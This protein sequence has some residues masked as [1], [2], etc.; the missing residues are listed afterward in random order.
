[1]R[2][3]VALVTGASTGLG[4]AI[5]RALLARTDHHVVLTARAGSMD[6]FVDAGLAE[7]ER[8][9]LRPLD[10]TVEAQRRALIDEIERELGGVDALINNAGVSYRAVVEHVR[11][12]ERLTQMDVNFRSPMELARLVLPRMR[13]RRRGHVVNVSSVAGMM[14]MPT[15]A[16]YAASKFA[17]EGASE[18]LWYEVRPF[19]IRVTLVQ[20]GFLHSS[21]FQNVR[22][23]VLSGSSQETPED[24]YH[25][26]YA[27]MSG[28]IER[29]MRRAIATPE[30]VARVVVRTI[31]RRRPPLRVTAT[32]DAFF[33]HW[34]RRLLPRSFYHWILYRMLPGVSA[35]GRSSRAVSP[36]LR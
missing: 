20:P 3:P 14:A 12:S 18:A 24:P 11:E 10:V 9:W 17:L 5:G 7:K 23:T 30:D 29:L 4:L 13:A 19:G 8:L 15:M 27:H 2:R 32:L 1:M 33:F 35:W 6:R 16:V 28:F 36:R 26:H 31:Q 25:D 22:S 34:L 21:S